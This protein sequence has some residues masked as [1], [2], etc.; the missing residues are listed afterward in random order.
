M[1]PLILSL[2]VWLYISIFCH[3]LGHFGCAKLIGMSPRL[4]KVGRGF[5][6]FRKRFFGAQLKL[7]IPPFG[8]LTYADDPD[9]GWSTFK[10]L[11]PKLII[12]LIGGCLANSVLLVFSISMLAYSG[13]GLFLYFICIDVVVIITNLAPIDVYVYGMKSPTDG[14][15]IFLILTHHNQRY[16]EELFVHYRKEVSRIAGDRADLQIVF[17]NNLRIL[18]LLEKAKTE[19]AYRHFDET[20]IILNRV[21]NNE[22]I[23]DSERAYILDT[24][25]SIVI[26]HRQK[27]YLTQAD[28]W[29]QEALRLAGYSKTIQGTRGA[30]LIE[31]G[32]YEEGK[33]MLFPLT[34]PDNDPID[35]AIS[36]YYLANAEHRLGNGEQAWRWLKQAEEAGK[37]A[38]DLSEMFASVKQELRE[39][40]N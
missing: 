39:S 20:I 15:H 30:I 8:G 25:A 24:L 31:L 19:L 13:F 12:Y 5:V 35:I 7:G 34:E 17:K 28:G 27:Q 11:K 21:L 32:K 23:A 6:I 26:N 16:H 29:S 1:I 2:L 18:Q 9:T 22:N 3:E 10:D 4:M 14:K 37:H 40:L 38:P 36:S 33:Q